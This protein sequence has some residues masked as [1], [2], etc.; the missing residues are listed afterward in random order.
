[1]KSLLLDEITRFVREDPGNAWPGL[2][3]P[4][5]EAPLV[6]VA[7]AS[8]PLF[9]SFKQVVAAHHLSPAEAFALAHPGAASAVRSV[10]SVALPVAAGIRRANARSRGQSA[11]AWTLLR[12]YGDD[13]FLRGLGDHLVRFL[14]ERGQR[15]VQP[16]RLTDFRIT[17]E[18]DGFGSSWSERHVAYAAGLGTFS[19]NDGFIT[20]KGMAVRFLSLVSDADLAPDPRMERGTHGNCLLKAGRRCGACFKRCPVGALSEQGHDKL[21]CR[22]QCYG[23]DSKSLAAERGGIPDLGSG[24]GLCQTGVPCESR[25]PM[26]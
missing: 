10:V 23:P 17:R 14:G 2:D 22:Q 19:A 5:Y 21:L 25:N 7:A 3:G 11:P 1:M 6:G 12:A 24:C 8:D 13:R 26:A 18:A 15:A 4:F 20:E 9:A 16:A